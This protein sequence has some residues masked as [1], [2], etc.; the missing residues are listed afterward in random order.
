M[1]LRGRP[2]SRSLVYTRTISVI[3]VTPLSQPFLDLLTPLAVVRGRGQ[4]TR[5]FLP[6][7]S[8]HTPTLEDPDTQTPDP[9]LN[10]LSFLSSFGVDPK[11]RHVTHLPPVNDPTPFLDSHSIRLKLDEN[12]M[13]SSLLNP[14]LS[15]LPF[16]S[17]LGLTPPTPVLHG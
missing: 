5:Q 9:F 8:S 3:D 13:T 1:T 6:P 12:S 2:K 15:T 16:T 14:W 10:S 4:V 11:T 17:T 7:S